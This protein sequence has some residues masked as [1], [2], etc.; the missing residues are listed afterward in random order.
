MK[1]SYSIVDKRVTP[2]TEPSGTSRIKESELNSFV[3][4]QYVEPKKLDM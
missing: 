3:N 2:C 4:A 1:E